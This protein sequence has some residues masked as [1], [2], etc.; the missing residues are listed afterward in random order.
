MGR[1]LHFSHDSCG[2]TVVAAFPALV[3]IP[4][5]LLQGKQ[6]T[7]NLIGATMIIAPPPAHEILSGHSRIVVVG[8]L[9][10]KRVSFRQRVIM[11]LSMHCRARLVG[12]L[13]RAYVVLRACAIRPLVENSEVLL[14]IG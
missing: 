13:G 2:G 1:F 10:R 7:F 4:S 14:K 9:F 5:P 6:E 3:P 12:S 8:I 11:L